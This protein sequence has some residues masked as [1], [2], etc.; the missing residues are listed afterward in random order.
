MEGIPSEDAL[1][2]VRRTSLAV[3]SALALASLFAAPAGA[4]EPDAA[5]IY[6]KTC[7][8]CHGPE[9]APNETFSK[10]G[11]RSFKDPEWQKATGD[12][13]LEKSI[14]EGKKGT[15]M[16]SFEKQFSAEEIKAL[17]AHVRK[18]GTPPAK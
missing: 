1:M 9:G 15:L 7:A 3:A 6:A 5:K 12:A 8:L 11:V 13:Q 16:A 17:V 14:R 18:L 2:T 4:A 10:M